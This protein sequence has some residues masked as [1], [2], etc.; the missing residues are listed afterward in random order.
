MTICERS[1]QFD[2]EVC[3]DWTKRQGLVGVI[4]LELTLGL[5]VGQVKGRRHRFDMAELQSPSPE[6]RR[7]SS[8]IPIES[9]FQLHP[10][11]RRVK[12]RQVVSITKLLGGNGR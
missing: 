4:D 9:L 1:V 6:V 11:S 5:S 2:P 7:E 8:H 10:F 12:Y 3:W